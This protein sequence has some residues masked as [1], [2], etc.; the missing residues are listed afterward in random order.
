MSQK[1]LEEKRIQVDCNS[2][3][4]I[5]KAIETAGREQI[6]AGKP[7]INPYIIGSRAHVQFERRWCDWCVTQKLRPGGNSMSE[8]VVR[9]ADIVRL[10]EAAARKHRAL[11]DATPVENPYPQGSIAALW[12]AVKFE[13]LMLDDGEKG[14]T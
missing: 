6:M 4:V 2:F 1:R 14:P 10:A 12:F 9:I 8:P 11:N 7:V 5:V 3:L 13:K